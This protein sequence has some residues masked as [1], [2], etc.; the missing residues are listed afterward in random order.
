MEVP[1]SRGASEYSGQDRRHAW[2]ALL[3]RACRGNR[4]DLPL[5]HG[6]G[7]DK[8]SGCERRAART[9]SEVPAAL[10]RTS[11]MLTMLKLP[12]RETGLPSSGKKSSWATPSR[13]GSAWGQ[14]DSE[15]PLRVRAR[16]RLQACE[17]DML[18]DD[19]GP[20]HRAGGL[21][22]HDAGHLRLAGQA[23]CRAS[24]DCQRAAMRGLAGKCF[25]ASTRDSSTHVWGE[26][27]QRCLIPEG[28]E[29]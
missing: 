7:H 8:R 6:L 1:F 23:D 20:F 14:S 12:A 10:E 4:I 5:C 21:V 9:S 13:C 24:Q 25:E 27:R 17:F 3:G 29:A 16:L 11:S 26:S 28:R 15:C 19:T 2:D 18:D 22:R